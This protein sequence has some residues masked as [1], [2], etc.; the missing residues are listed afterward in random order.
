MNIQQQIERNR[1]II[2]ALPERLT[3]VEV[4][5]PSILAHTTQIVWQAKEETKEA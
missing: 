1:E 4:W 5:E 3:F 2:R